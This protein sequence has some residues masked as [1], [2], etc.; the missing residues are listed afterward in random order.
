ME[1]QSDSARPEDRL[2]ARCWAAASCKFRYELSGLCQK[3][4]KG[5]AGGGSAIGRPASQTVDTRAPPRYVPGARPLRRARPRPPRRYRHPSPLSRPRPAICQSSRS[6]QSVSLSV[7]SVLR[8]RS[9]PSRWNLFRLSLEPA[10]A[11]SGICAS[12]SP[13]PNCDGAL[14]FQSRGPGQVCVFLGAA[15]T[16]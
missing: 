11:Y 10:A 8:S 14:L 3:A 5:A 13:T 9:A 6:C 15:T 12:K 4:G 16:A 1:R 7:K 2:L